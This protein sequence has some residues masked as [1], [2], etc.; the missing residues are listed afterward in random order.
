MIA[1][2]IF[3]SLIESLAESEMSGQPVLPDNVARSVQYIAVTS[4]MASIIAHN[5]KEP[6]SNQRLLLGNKVDHA[7]AF[8]ANRYPDS[9][10][11]VDAVFQ[12][13]EKVALWHSASHYARTQSVSTCIP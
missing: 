5:R 4:R 13:N 12:W 7:A 2:N 9:I 6:A 11:N 10:A 3:D 1:L 8:S